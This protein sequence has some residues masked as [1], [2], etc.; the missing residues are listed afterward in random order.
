MKNTRGR[1]DRDNR[2]SIDL[3][4]RG[5]YERGRR[6]QRARPSGSPLTGLLLIGSTIAMALL[7]FMVFRPVG[8]NAADQAKTSQT[9]S[10]LNSSAPSSDRSNP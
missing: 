2:E 8:T 7:L 6:D 1:Y 10:A 4:L 5:A 3:E 9:A